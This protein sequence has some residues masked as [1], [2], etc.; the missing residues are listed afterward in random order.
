MDKQFIRLCRPWTSSE[1]VVAVREVLDSGCLTQ[2][3]KT[4]EF[5]I[6]VSKYVGTRYAFATSSCTTALH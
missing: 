3:P 1:E 2:G 4:E 6:A 5:E